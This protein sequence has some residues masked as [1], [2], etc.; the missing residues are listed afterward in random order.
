MRLPI[1]LTCAVLMTLT[2]G[3]HIRRVVDREHAALSSCINGLRQIDGAKEQWALD[4]HVKNG[5]IVTTN[6]IAPYGGIPVCPQGGTYTLGRVGELPKC[7][8]G[9][10]GHSLE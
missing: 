8:I 4:N 3:C 5:A 10:S 7:S 6:D 1:S 2:I 9:E